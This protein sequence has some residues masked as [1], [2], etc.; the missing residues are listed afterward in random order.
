MSSDVP[1]E[2][3][4]QIAFIDAVKYCN[5]V[6][7]FSTNDLQ[8][9]I[10]IIE[11]ASTVAGGAE[12]LGEKPYLFFYCEPIPPL[13][14]P[15]ASVEKLRIAAEAKIPVVYMPFCMMGGTA[16]MSPSG[17]LAQCNAEVLAGLIIT[18]AIN[19]GAP[20]IYGAMPSIFDMKTTIGSYAA[21]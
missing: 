7:N 5:K 2:I 6:V 16:V 19:E 17:A 13:T 12:L 18:Q 8:G 15:E 21:P 10:A 9:L 11:I 14:H 1:P 4:S 20:F 3:Q